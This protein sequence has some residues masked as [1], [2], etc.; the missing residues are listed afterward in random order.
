MAAG[1]PYWN[2]QN[3]TFTILERIPG[4]H[5]PLAIQPFGILVATGVVIGAYLMRRWG[6]KHGLDDNHVRGLVLYSAIFG[7]TGAHLFDVIAYE[8]HK[9]VED[10]LVLIRLWEGISSYG[11]FIGGSFGFF[12]YQRRNRLPFGPYGDCTIIGLVTAFTVGRLGCTVVHDH[13]GAASDGFF[14]AVDYPVGKIPSFPADASGLHHNLG[15]YEFLYL[16]FVCAV[17]YGASKWKDRP[18]GLLVALSA[19]VYA[20]VRFFLDYLRINPDADPR[21]LTLTFAQ[22]ASIAT[23]GAGA[24]LIGRLVRSVRDTPASEPA[25]EDATPETSKPA[26]SKST[27][28]KQGAGTASASKTGASKTGTTK[29]RKRK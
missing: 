13:V 22:W 15:L 2:P 11:G 23:V 16:L 26:A 21:Y 20:P 24:F 10:P 3:I 29:R 8:P 17:L 1:L 4:T 25:T 7:F 12:L 5:M 19:T 18:A 14:L 27:T 9:L 6:E 28:S